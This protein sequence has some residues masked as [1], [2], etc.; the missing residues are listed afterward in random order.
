MGMGETVRRAA[1]GL[2]QVIFMTHLYHAIQV[3]FGFFYGLFI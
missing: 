2:Q 1:K 3:L